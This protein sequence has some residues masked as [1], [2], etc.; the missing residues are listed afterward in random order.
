M[1]RLLGRGVLLSQ[2]GGGVTLA[3]KQSALALLSYQNAGSISLMFPSL[4]HVLCIQTR[5]R[6]NPGPNLPPTG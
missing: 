2:R 3:L 6:G 1:Q 5:I 4:G